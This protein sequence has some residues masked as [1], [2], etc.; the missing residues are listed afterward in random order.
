M[1]GF[2]NLNYEI[3]NPWFSNKAK[4]RTYCLEELMATK[5]CAL[6][7]RSKGRDLY[8]LWLAITKFDL[9]CEKT[10]TA[11]YQYCDAR[12]VKISRAEYE[13]NLIFKMK[14]ND[15]ISDAAKVLPANASWNI[16]EAFQSIMQ[17]M[18]TKL[19]GEPWKGLNESEA[20]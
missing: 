11:F 6:Y 9:H 13:K 4:I 10:I 2:E 7:Q 15:F 14:S 18:V 16:E 17:N 12:G 5:F 20:G 8:D 19:D 3:K 1:Y